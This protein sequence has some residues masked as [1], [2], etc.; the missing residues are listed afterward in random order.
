MHYSGGSSTHDVWAQNG[1]VSLGGPT[2]ANQFF[3]GRRPFR[4][5]VFPNGTE[6]ADWIA[7]YSCKK[8]AGKSASNAGQLIHPSIGGRNTKRKFG[9]PL[10]RQRHRRDPAERR[11]HEGADREV[12]RPERLRRQVRVGHQPGRG[13]DPGHRRRPDRGQGHDAGLPVR[14]DRSGVPDQRPHP[15]QLLPRAPAVRRVPHRLR[16]ARPALRPGPVGA[17]LRAEPAGQPGAVRAVGRGQDLAGVGSQRSAVCVV[18]PRHRL[19]H[20]DRF[21][22]PGRRAQP[23]PAHHRAGP[24]RQ[25][26]QTGGWE[27]TGGNPA[28]YLLKFGPEDYTAISDFREV[29][30]DA[31][32]RSDDRRQERRLHPHEQGPAV[33]R[34]ASSTATFAIPAKPQ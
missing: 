6:T 10:L 19:H 32:A 7:E 3:A 4:W 22:D 5:D 31:T 21:D 8:L 1:I 26:S 33:R 28:A 12:H 14:P 2:Q 29:Y 25:A 16:R 11:A 34:P 30:W 23:E 18:Q 15:Q 24:G 9:D 27:A 20:H 13:A 17:R